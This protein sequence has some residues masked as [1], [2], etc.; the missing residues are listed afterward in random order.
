MEAVEIFEKWQ[1]KELAEKFCQ[2]YIFL[3]IYVLLLIVTNELCLSGSIVVKIWPN[4]HSLIWVL[5]RLFHRQ[6]KGL[7]FPRHTGDLEMI[8]KDQK[9][10]RAIGI[11]WPFLNSIICL[12][13]KT[14]KMI[15]REPMLF[16][17]KITL[18]LIL[19]KF[20]ITPKKK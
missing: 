7:F 12:P 16:L 13:L 5:Y 14:K 15:M 19:M 20:M 2:V 17:T 1:K 9:S 6:F 18:K 3:F 11:N 8:V 10:C 4:N